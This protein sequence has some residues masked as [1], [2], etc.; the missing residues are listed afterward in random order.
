MRPWKS[1]CGRAV[2]WRGDCRELLPMLSAHAV[3]TDPPYGTGGWKRPASGAG[4]DGSAVYARAE[5][6]QWDDGWL[7]LATAPTV[8]MFVPQTRLGEFKRLFFWHKPDPRPRFGGQ[9]AYAF[10]PFV[11]VRGTV[12]KC[13]GTDLITASAPRLNRD[14]EAVGHPHQKPIRVMAW[15]IER[16][17]DAGEIVLDPFMGSGST[18]VAALR[19]GRRF[20]GIEQDASHFVTAKARIRAE[21]KQLAEA[22]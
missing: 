15:C 6:D 8:G 1:K 14:K 5:W 16:C 20:I 3:V 21:L 19:T 4:S 17:A 18:G 2:L 22:A 13:G 10:E 7:T 11:I 12:R 9:P